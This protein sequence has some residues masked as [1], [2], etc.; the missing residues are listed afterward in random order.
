MEKPID[1]RF[2]PY[3]TL[4]TL[5]LSSSW[6]NLGLLYGTDCI[7]WV[8]PVSSRKILDGSTALVLV[9]SSVRDVFRQTD[10]LQLHNSVLRS[11]TFDS[12][13]P[14]RFVKVITLTLFR[15]SPF[16]DGSTAWVV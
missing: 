1:V 15:P 14:V 7:G 6:V 16:L 12:T 4:D 11:L 5:D 13:H 10:S 2:S 3:G 9:V 8:V